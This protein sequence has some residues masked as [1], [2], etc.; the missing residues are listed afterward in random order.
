MTRA[1]PTSITVTR[2]PAMATRVTRAG[3]GEIDMSAQRED[4]ILREMRVLGLAQ[5]CG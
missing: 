1:A 4:S 2:K 5:R 3:R